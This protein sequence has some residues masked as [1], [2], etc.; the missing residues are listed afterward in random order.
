[1]LRQVLLPSQCL[2]MTGPRLCGSFVNR[3]HRASARTEHLAYS[4]YVQGWWTPAVCQTRPIIAWLCCRQG[5]LL[6]HPCNVL[7]QRGRPLKPCALE[8]G[9]CSTE[10]QHH[11]SLPVPSLASCYAC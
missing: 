10:P 9:I 11:C 3:M 4:F 1:M 6:L 2:H 8:A 5:V 7:S